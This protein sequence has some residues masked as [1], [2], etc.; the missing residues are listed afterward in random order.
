MRLS[1]Q[2]LVKISFLV[3]MLSAQL[4]MGQ[5]LADG[6]KDNSTKDAETS[7]QATSESTPDLLQGNQA[8]PAAIT[9]TKQKKCNIIIE[10]SD[11][12]FLMQNKG[13]IFSVQSE[14]QT[15]PAKVNRTQAGK[16][17]ASLKKSDCEKN[18]VG[19]NVILKNNDQNSSSSKSKK[20]T[21]SQELSESQDSA[22]SAVT[23]SNKITYTSKPSNNGFQTLLGTEQLITKAG[24]QMLKNYNLRATY[25]WFDAPQR[26]SQRSK[27]GAIAGLGLS[28]SGFD[29]G[30]NLAITG[31]VLSRLGFRMTSKEFGFTA[32]GTFKYV[33]LIGTVNKFEFFPEDAPHRLGIDLQF[34]YE[35]SKGMKIVVVPNYTMIVMNTT[36]QADFT[37]LEYLAGLWWL[38]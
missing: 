1:L 6:E 8:T 23:Q 22:D 10:T 4:A 16:V 18:V 7:H 35:I 2:L 33:T 34:D 29:V 20:S 9:V 37:L 17:F 5:T 31:S 27:E 32:A 19:A 11:S 15:I 25:E 3:L 38:F 13:V 24:S 14:S 21:L 12:N 28:M 36:S 26:I 30:S